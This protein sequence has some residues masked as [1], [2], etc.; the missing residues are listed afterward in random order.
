MKGG[1]IDGMRDEKREKKDQVKEG[2]KSKPKGEKRRPD[3]REQK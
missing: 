2:D 1:L 3:C